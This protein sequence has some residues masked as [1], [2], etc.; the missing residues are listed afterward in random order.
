MGSLAERGSPRRKGWE[1]GGRVGSP[2]KLASVLASDFPV[3]A[4][5]GAITNALLP[6]PLLSDPRSSSL[7]PVTIQKPR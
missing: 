4:Q 5:R 3:S 1:G 2:E 7:R 6:A